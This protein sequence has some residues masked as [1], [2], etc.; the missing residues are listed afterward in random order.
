LIIRHLNDGL[1]EAKVEQLQQES[2]RNAG[3]LTSDLSHHISEA[4]P[5]TKFVVSEHD[6]TRLALGLGE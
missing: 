1:R 5:G 3:A 6:E 2:E 4:F